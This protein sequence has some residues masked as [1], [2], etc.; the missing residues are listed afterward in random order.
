VRERE[1]GGEEGWGEREGGKG[2]RERGGGEGREGEGRGR[3]GSVHFVLFLE[4]FFKSGGFLVIWGPQCAA[5]PT[6]QTLP[7]SYVA[8]S[9]QILSPEGPG[10][11]PGE[12]IH[13]VVGVQGPWESG[14]AETSAHF[15]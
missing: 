5:S 6:L 11:G 14:V 13:Q 10:E 1:R 8:H 2:E 12:G 4:S 9:S 7:P 3:E 15:D